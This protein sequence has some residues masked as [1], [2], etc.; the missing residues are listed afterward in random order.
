MRQIQDVTSTQDG[1]HLLI[2]LT[3]GGVLYFRAGT[4]ES[5]ADSGEQSETDVGQSIQTAK[6]GCRATLTE[7]SKLSFN[8]MEDSAWSIKR[9]GAN[10]TVVLLRATRSDD[11]N[12]LT[13]LSVCPLSGQY[14]VNVALLSLALT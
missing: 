12:G 1:G 14:I 2:L 3:D 9:V 13:T 10:G 5:H 7:F 4:E 6:G 8:P 11:A